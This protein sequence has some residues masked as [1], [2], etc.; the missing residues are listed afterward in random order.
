MT[1]IL[2]SRQRKLSWSAYLFLAPAFL[3]IVPFVL[4]PVFNLFYISLF[5][6]SLL[7]RMKFIGLGNFVSLFTND[8]F[9]SSLS[10]SAVF[11]VSVVIIQTVIA[12]FVALL[13]EAESRRMGLIRTIFFIPVILSFVVVSYLW[14]FIYNSDFGLLAAIFDGL[15]V[16]RQGFLSDPAQALPSLIATCVWKSWA[17]FMMIFFAGLKEIPQEL[18]ECAHLEGAN[19]FQRARYVTLPLLKRT[20]LFVVVVTTMDA[21][22]RVFTPVFVMTDGGPRGATDLLIYFDWRQAFR[23]GDLGYAASIAVFMFFFV[24]IVSLI[25][26]NLGKEDHA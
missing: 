17:F 4:Y 25:Q 12:L 11:M 15:G 2:L 14:K 13:V 16:Q 3:V 26:L 5:K 1:D 22:V 23:L 20:I 10:V 21:V 8:D 18:H 7:G 9:V 19:G 24:L 6:A